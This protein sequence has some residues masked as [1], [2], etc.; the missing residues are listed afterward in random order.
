MII[1]LL[2]L[3]LLLPPPLLLES[4]VVDC[5]VLAAA[6]VALNVPQTMFSCARNVTN[7]RRQNISLLQRHLRA[8]HRLV[9]SSAKFSYNLF[10]A[11]HVWKYKR[12]AHF[13][14]FIAF[15]AVSTFGMSEFPTQNQKQIWLFY[16]LQFF[17][18]IWSCRIAFLKMLFNR[19]F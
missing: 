12:G 1:V 4:V 3:L 6:R 16:A 14:I 9:G 17:W 8:S 10:K 5:G 19:H 2:L 13:V 15:I 11:A 18:T 7:E